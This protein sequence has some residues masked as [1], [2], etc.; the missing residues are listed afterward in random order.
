[1]TLPNDAEIYLEVRKNTE[2]LHQYHMIHDKAKEKSPHSTVVGADPH[3][4]QCGRMPTLEVIKY[5]EWH[6]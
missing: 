4:H 2:D 1:M 6:I 3:T 5:M